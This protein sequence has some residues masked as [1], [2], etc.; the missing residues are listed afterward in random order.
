MK[1]LFIV[2]YIIFNYA[3]FNYEETFNEPDCG[4]YHGIKIRTCGE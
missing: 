3:E 2:A 1:I 4:F